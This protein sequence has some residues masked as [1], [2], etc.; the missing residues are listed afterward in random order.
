MFSL[1]LARFILKSLIPTPVT[2]EVFEA[3]LVT[4]RAFEILDKITCFL[5]VP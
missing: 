5:D 2:I 3:F 1:I 4:I